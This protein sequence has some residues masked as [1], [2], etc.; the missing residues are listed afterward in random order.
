MKKVFP[1][2]ETNH[3]IWLSRGS[4]DSVENV[5]ALCPNCHRKMH[6]LYIESDVEKLKRKAME[7]SKV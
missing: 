2:S 7:N 3:I 5:I 1:N 6:E 4:D